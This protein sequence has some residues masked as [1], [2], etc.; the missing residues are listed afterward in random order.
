[1][2]FRP[3]RK[4][5]AMNPQGQTPNYDQKKGSA[6]LRTQG[7]P[8]GLPGER[9]AAGEPRLADIVDEVEGR[10]TS[11]EGTDTIPGQ[12]GCGPSVTDYPG[13]GAP[14]GEDAQSTGS[15]A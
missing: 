6:D 15:D 13:L 9:I 7:Q 5:H 11:R 3:R 2:R 8:E 4:E 1:M 10:A 14:R 12:P